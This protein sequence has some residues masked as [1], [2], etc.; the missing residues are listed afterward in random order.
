M[1]PVHHLPEELLVGYAAGALA[2]AE[3]LLVACHAS[4]CG[5]CARRVRE[6]E[7]LGGALLAKEAAVELSD[8]LLTRTLALLDAQPRAPEPEPVRDP[9]LPAPLARITG[10]FDKIVWTPTLS[11][12]HTLELPLKLGHVPV[13]LRRLRA[14]TH[15]PQHTHRALEYDMIL[16]GGLSDDRNGIHFERGDVAVNDERDAHSLTIDEG[17]EC[18]ALSVHGA[19]VKPI[20]LWS[21]LVFGYTRW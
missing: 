12:V 16:A 3:A 10:P 20:G 17:V 11:N 14:G 19:R 7:Q 6:L 2:E 5:A 21:R 8:D 15:I 4:L 1:I 9:I 13:R 18:V